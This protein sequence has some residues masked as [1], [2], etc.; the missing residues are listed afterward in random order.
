MRTICYLLLA[1]FT[2]A[3]G[4]VDMAE[5]SVGDETPKGTVVC[6][7]GGTAPDVP[8]D[9]ETVWDQWF[10]S[11]MT[12]A[13]PSYWLLHYGEW[14]DVKAADNF[15]TDPEY[16]GYVLSGFD[17]EFYYQSGGPYNV[18]GIFALVWSDGGGEP[19]STEPYEF[20][21]H[22]GWHD[23][24]VG[25]NGGLKYAGIAGLEWADYWTYDNIEETT[26]DYACY[27]E[28]AHMEDAESFQSKEYY[29]AFDSTRDYWFCIQRYQGDWGVYCGPRDWL[30]NEINYAP[31]A[32]IAGLEGPSWL[33]PDPG[34]IMDVAFVLY[35]VPA[36]DDLNV[37]AK[38]LGRIKAAFR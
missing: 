32:K 3:A 21:L 22:P 36:P 11:G 18:F 28:H 29:W 26:D 23:D 4:S 5:L 31:N 9:W 17:A 35:G 12:V 8:G 33:D 14:Y 10:S 16:D 38:S 6:K 34:Q 19:A 20:G 1:A 13:L 27:K 25:G 24:L 7:G 15:K 37:E 2:A 30:G